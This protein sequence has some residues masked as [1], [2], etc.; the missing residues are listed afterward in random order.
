MYVKH[1]KG[2][3]PAEPSRMAVNYVNDA[4]WLPDDH[5]DDILYTTSALDDL[6]YD[7]GN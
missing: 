2:A 4:T 6:G 5:V 1:K 7:H 3:W